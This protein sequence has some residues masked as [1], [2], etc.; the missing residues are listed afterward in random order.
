MMRCP[1]AISVI[2]PVANL[3]QVCEVNG[4]DGSEVIHDRLTL[5]EKCG[6][7]T[8]EVIPISDVT[9]CEYAA[10]VCRGIQENPVW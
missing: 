3:P 10:V 1:Y 6:Q 9:K 7:R 2:I 4:F 5:T 8:P